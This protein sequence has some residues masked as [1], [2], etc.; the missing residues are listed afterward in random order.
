MQYICIANKSEISYTVAY[1][2]MQFIKHLIRTTSYAKEKVLLEQND[3]SHA[4]SRGTV[5]PIEL[6]HD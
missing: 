5:K 4:H 2:L 3:M 6:S 1:I